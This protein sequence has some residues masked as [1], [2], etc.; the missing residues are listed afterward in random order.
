MKKHGLRLL[1][2]DTLVILLSGSRST[3]RR[4]T[5]RTSRKRTAH[6]NQWQAR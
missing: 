2:A 1:N 6:P 4:V 3:L 5:Y